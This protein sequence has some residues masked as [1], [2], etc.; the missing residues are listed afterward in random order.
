MKER[1]KVETRE[2]PPSWNDCSGHS[3]W[4]EY[5]VK[6]NG[7]TVLDTFGEGDFF[8]DKEHAIEAAKYLMSES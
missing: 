8:E 1:I 2:V 5:R 7:K 3:G 6:I 4:T